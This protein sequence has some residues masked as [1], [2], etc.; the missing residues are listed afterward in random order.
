[1]VI[2]I[3]IEETPMEY[4]DILNEMVDTGS[5]S[6]DI[7]LFNAVRDLLNT[8]CEAMQDRNFE[9]A[10]SSI[11]I[12]HD[13][14]EFIEPISIDD[15]DP[16]DGGVYLSEVEGDLVKIKN[17]PIH[18]VLRVLR[19]TMDAALTALNNGDGF[20][21]GHMLRTAQQL[22]ALVKIR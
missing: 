3:Q 13:Q 20:A 14:L 21:S 16:S 12:A 9:T 22:A 15:Y 17:M 5:D 7:L 6:L 19:T 18:Q 1:M 8:G 4:K 10:D 2:W 11:R